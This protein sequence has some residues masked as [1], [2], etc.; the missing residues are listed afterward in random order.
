MTRPGKPQRAG[1]DAVTSRMPAASPRS[2]SSNGA[3]GSTAVDAANASSSANT[4]TTLLPVTR[5]AH[6]E[7]SLLPVTPGAGVTADDR[8]TGGSDS[9]G[10]ATSWSA[11]EPPARGPRAAARRIAYRAAG[12]DPVTWISWLFVLNFLTQRLSLPGISIP[13]TVPLTVVWLLAGW[14]LGV[15]AIE[16]RRTLLWLIGA[17]AS[18]LVVLP[19]VLFVKS[20]YVSVNSWAFWMV[21]WIPACFMLVDR[22]KE[23]FERALRSVSTI[24]VWL[25]AL[26]ASFIL[27]QFAGVPYVDYVR[28]VVPSQFIV[29]GFNTAYPFFYGSPLIK[30]NGWLALEPSFMSFA[31]GLCIMAGLLCGARVWKVA[32]MGIGMLATVA[33]S[34]M[35][36]V[37]AGIV[38]MLVLRQ[39]YLL[40]RY[41]V[42]GLVLGLVAAPTQIGQVILARMSE[43][44]SSNSSTALRTFEPYQYLFPRWVESFPKIFFGGGAGSSRQIV[45]GSGVD[46]LLVPTTAKVFYDYGAIAG[47]VL[48][49][50]VLAC[51]VR[52]PA[53]ALGYAVLTSM[54]VIQ[55]PA[56]PLMIPAFLLTTLWAPV[57]W[58]ERDVG[59]PRRLARRLLRRRPTPIPPPGPPPATG[60]HH[61]P[62]HVGPAEKVE[63]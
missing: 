12:G 25:G 20:P 51:Y 60:A 53:P 32:V 55:P 1:A 43:G 28:K 16:P 33:G 8:R 17:G 21:I 48:M 27:L 54:L 14:R 47:A 58:R 37:L 59:A 35:A 22:S 38:A 46:G 52:T 29:Q 42:P 10:E 56:Q 26:S 19:Q 5:P 40:K 31:L 49:F 24:G 3:G 50:L 63:R 11:T 41:L 6:D 61:D 36:I 13:V 23:T 9:A 7:T 15:L 34:G 2:A 57:P 45:E 62:S 39:G 30:S 44:S 4:S 18:A